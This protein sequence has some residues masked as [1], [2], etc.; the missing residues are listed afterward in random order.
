MKIVVLNSDLDN[1]IIT[2]IVMT[3]ALIF[4][5]K[6]IKDKFEARKPLLAKFLDEEI[7]GQLDNY[8]FNF[9][10]ATFQEKSFDLKTKIT[11]VLMS[12]I[13]IIMPLY[14]MIETLRPPRYFETFSCFGF[15][16]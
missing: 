11:V 10:N 3:T 16:I 1:F 9:E 15:G 12:A 7:E 4:V 14:Q 13:V 5:L 8:T 6:W 2:C